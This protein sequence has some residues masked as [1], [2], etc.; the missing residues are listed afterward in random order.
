MVDLLIGAITYDLKYSEG[1]VSG[2]KYK[3]ELVEYLKKNLGLATFKDGFKNRDFNIF[4]NKEKEG[5]K[6]DL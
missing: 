5:E 3:L 4:V 6:T 1:I 2:S